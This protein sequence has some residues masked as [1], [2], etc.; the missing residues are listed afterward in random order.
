MVLQILKL[1]PFPEKVH[2]L[3]N[4]VEKI[5]WILFLFITQIFSKDNEI[6]RS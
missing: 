1:I 5:G 3:F 4:F 2:F 6:S